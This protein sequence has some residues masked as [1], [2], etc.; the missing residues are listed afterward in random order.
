MSTSRET[1]NHCSQSFWQSS[2]SFVLLV[3][4]LSV[5]ALHCVLDN[6][7]CQSRDNY[8]SALVDNCSFAKRQWLFHLPLSWKI[9]NQWWTKLHLQSID[10][11]CALLLTCS[12]IVIQRV[13][14]IANLPKYSLQSFK[15][16]HALSGGAGWQIRCFTVCQFCKKDQS[17]DGKWNGYRPSLCSIR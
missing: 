6:H 9:V 5:L 7:W 3:H 16:W 1:D 13:A 12:W 2:Q 10:Q 15:R 11:Y 14:H 8:C 17:A 4:F